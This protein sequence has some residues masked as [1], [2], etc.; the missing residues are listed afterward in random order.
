MSTLIWNHMLTWS[1]Q[2]TAFLS[3]NG[4][5]QQGWPNRKYVSNQLSV[6]S[7]QN[8]LALIRLSR[9]VNWNKLPQV[10]PLLPP[11]GALIGSV[12]SSISLCHCGLKLADELIHI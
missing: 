3:M 7:L 2:W 4:S 10:N 9:H 1:L 6:A 11:Q 5:F 12:S 8:D